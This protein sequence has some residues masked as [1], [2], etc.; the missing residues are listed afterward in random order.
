MGPA[1]S[2]EDPDDEPEP[3]ELEDTGGGGVKKIRIRTL[4]PMI[5]QINFTFFGTE[6]R[7]NKTCAKMVLSAHVMEAIR[8]DQ[9]FMA[10]REVR[11]LTEAAWNNTLSL[12][13]DHSRHDG[14]DVIFIG[15]STIRIGAYLLQAVERAAPG[16]V[17]KSRRLS[18]DAS[19]LICTFRRTKTGGEMGVISVTQQFT[20]QRKC[21]LAEGAHTISQ[22]CDQKCEH[23]YNQTSTQDER[24]PKRHIEP[25]MCA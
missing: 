5:C 23:R 10:V 22:N 13:C 7:V 20:T 14:G 16:T 24:L 18:Q 11:I 3:P 19:H 4:H 25:S 21:V 2:R 12:W 8:V 17:C 1:A 6:M 9:L 15:I